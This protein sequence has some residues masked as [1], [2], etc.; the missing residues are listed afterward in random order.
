MAVKGRYD[1]LIPVL[2]LLG[3]HTGYEKCIVADNFRRAEFVDL[4]RQFPFRRHF[5]HQEVA[6]TDVGNGNAEPLVDINDSHQIVVLRLIQ[7]LGAGDGS[8][9]DDTD[10]LSFYQSLGLFGVFHLLR[11]SYLVALLDQPVQIVIKRMVGNAA[12][13]RPF[14]QAAFFSCQS[15]LQFLRDGER[16]FKKHLIK[17]PQPVKQ[18]TV[19]VLLLGFQIMDHH[20]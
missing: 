4:I 13:G 3:V 15:N 12:H 10:N 6:C 19:R 18:D 8:G 9:G 17:I 20:W 7:C 11:N 14:L 5:S 16:I 1:C 2:D